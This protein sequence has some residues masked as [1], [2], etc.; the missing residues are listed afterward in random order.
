MCISLN[1][2]LH[3]FVKERNGTFK[4]KKTPPAIGG[5]NSWRV[6]TLN[7]PYR[8]GEIQYLI[9]QA[10]P[11]KT[12][13]NFN[14]NLGLDLLIYR[15]DWMDK[16]GKLFGLEEYQIGVED[17]D[18]R[19]IIKG[20]DKTFI[21]KI[22]DKPIRESLMQNSSFCN[23]MLESKADKSKLSLNA[24]FSESNTIHMKETYEFFQNMVDNIMDYYE[25]N[26]T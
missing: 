14:F 4:E 9:S 25:A 3:K 7:L 21:T 12:Y 22:F 1:E 24:P 2:Y 6:I 8:N 15:E 10:S 5:M 13:Y 26:K 23:L 19:F 11:M 16:L 20:T 17:F 18:N